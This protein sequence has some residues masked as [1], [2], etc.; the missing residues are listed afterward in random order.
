MCGIVGI[1][2]KNKKHIDKN[3]LSRL[4]NS[5]SHRGPDSFG[6][7]INKEKNLGLG[8][9]RLSIIDLRAVA[10][11]PMTAL[12]RYTIVFNGEIYNFH[13]LKKELLEL[14]HKFR[15]NSDTEV[16]LRSYIQWGE[17]CQLKFNGMWAF[18][19]WDDMKKELFISRDRY[20]VKPL[21]YLN[22]QVNFIF[23]SELKSFMKLNS[24]KIPDFDEDIFINQAQNYTNFSY[25]VGEKTFLKN[26]KELPPGF[27]IKIQANLI[28]LKKRWWKTIDNL[29][30]IQGTSDKIKKDFS[31][32]FLDSCNLRM[33][34]DVKVATSLSGGIDSSSIVSAINELKKTNKIYKSSKFPHET[35]ILDY[36]GEKNN[37]T[38]FA[39]DV[40]NYLKIK[41]RIISVKPSDFSE[42]EIKK[43]IFHQEEVT[44]DDGLGPWQIYKNMHK[45]GVKVSIDGHGGD[46]LL[47]GYSGYPKIAMQDINP[48]SNFL[49]W[50][51]LL[52]IHIIMNDK[53]YDEKQILKIFMSKMIDIFKNR[54]FRKKI[55]ND[56][57]NFF[58]ETNIKQDS[59]EYD[60]LESLNNLNK[61]LYI[62]YHY[63][64][65]SLNL[66]KYDKFS[67]AHSIET[68]FPFLDYRLACFSFSLPNQFKI[69]NG[70]TKKILRD[71]MKGKL[72]E[73]ILSRVKKKGFNPENTYFNK[74]YKKF[75]FDT[76]SSKSFQCENLWKGD[77]IKCH[78]ENKDVNLK[79]IFKFIQIFYIKKTFKDFSNS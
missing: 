45:N 26:V 71:I 53:N 28:I 34:S 39:L 43:I 61:N 65:M 7:Y 13:A 19:I 62:D 75:I 63:K 32:L 57:T 74:E 15:S 33:I 24:D 35:Y 12:D 6:I 70:Y 2:E 47:G 1:L 68:R 66:K 30:E 55:K 4:N 36:V 72:P 11:Q 59:V 54:L 16:L 5:L 60:N 64:A 77:E 76:V 23:S 40:S 17:D 9:R 42:E 73:N 14:G 50:V 69:K 10:N 3:E 48:I 38:N 29:Q 67:M 22:N 79:N 37:E 44:G 31:N 58:N 49:Y 56:Y 18:S 41:P 46:E 8:H 78:L 20:G 25:S 27:Q 51:D 21:Y 52:K